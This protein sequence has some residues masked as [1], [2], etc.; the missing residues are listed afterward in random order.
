MWKISHQSKVLFLWLLSLFLP[1]GASMAQNPSKSHTISG[2]VTDGKSQETLIGASVYEASTMKGTVTNNFGYYTLKLGE[3][4]VK[5]K[6]S[7]V[8]F[9]PYEAVFNLKNDTII[10][11][12]LSQ[13]NQHS[14][15]T[16]TP[17]PNC[18]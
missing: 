4:Q 16:G 7:F 9:A 15:R 17:E 12:A 6:A 14:P 2:Y 18:E 1:L 5:M 11:I 8:G 10:N 13:S 3:G